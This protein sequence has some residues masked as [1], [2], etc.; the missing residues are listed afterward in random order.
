MNATSTSAAR[1]APDGVR[2]VHRL[3]GLIA[4]PFLLVSIVLA[5]G[6]SHAAWLHALSDAIYPTRTIP[7]V[8]LDEPVRPGSWD[9]ALRL[10]QA[11]VGAPGHVITT[12]RDHVVAIGGF[13]VHAHDPQ[14]ATH[15]PQTVVLVDTT[16]MRIVRVEDR[17]TSLFTQAHGVHAYRF[18]GIDGLG[19]ST[20]SALALL[21][22][23]GTGVMLAR[24]DRQAGRTWTPASRRH[25]WAGRVLGLFMLLM[26]VTTLDFEFGFLR[27][28]R[29]A[30]H[31]LPAVRLDEP[32]QPGSIDQARRLAERA[33]GAAPR[34]VF[35]RAAN[36]L[37]FSEAGD[38]IGGA[39]VWVDGTTQTLNR[40]TD[41]RNDV[42]ALTFIVH[43][44][45][46]LGGLNA[47]NINDAAALGLLFLT[48]SGVGIWRT[49]RRMPRL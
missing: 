1:P 34:G 37:K 42:Q 25:V 17:H 13:A 39:S 11:A 33:I 28:G 14:A 4:V 49:R 46:W 24:R 43:D 21:V 22:L 7:Q 15:N 29:S 8:Q 31:P 9:Q 18:F 10:A 26:A 19:V 44:G 41:W 23:L 30:S 45:R 16:A 12:R 48:L 5:L 32:V 38:G 36:D 35:I 3:A 27:G 6:L 20:L 2:L 40:I 47:F